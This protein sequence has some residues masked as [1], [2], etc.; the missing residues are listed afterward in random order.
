M[1]VD[2]VAGKI[3]LSL[4]CGVRADLVPDGPPLQ[5]PGAD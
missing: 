5:P 3:C 2:D 1:R 4:I